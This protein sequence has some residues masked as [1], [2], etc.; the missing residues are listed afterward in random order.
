MTNAMILILD[1][2]SFPFLDVDVPCTAS[3]SVYIGQRIRFAARVSSHLT[4]FNALNAVLSL[5]FRLF[6]V[7]CCSIFNVFNFNTSVRPICLV[8]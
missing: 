1:I 2:V 4:D 5:R 3:Y 7:W 6:Y 8:Q